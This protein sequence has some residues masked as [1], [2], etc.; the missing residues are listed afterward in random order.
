MRRKTHYSPKRQRHHRLAFEPLESRHLLAVDLLLGE[1]LADGESTAGG[2]EISD[3]ALAAVVATVANLPASRI[4]SF[5]AQVGVEVLDIGDDAPELF[6]HWGTSDGITTIGDWDNEIPLGIS[7]IGTL[8]ADLIELTQNTQYH[9]R[10]RA[11]NLAGASWA[12]S[13]ESFTTI[14]LA[15]ATL[16]TDPAESVDVSTAVIFGDVTDTG[17]DTPEVTIYYGPTDGETDTG[18]W[19]SSVVIG[20]R[21]DSFAT[22]LSGLDAETTYFFRAQASNAFGESWSPL[23]RSFTT[24]AAPELHISEFMAI[25]N[26]TLTTRTRDSTGDAFGGDLKT[27]DWIEVHNLTDQPIDLGGMHLTDRDDELQRWAFPAG[28]SI[29]ASGYLVVFA[30]GDSITDPALD[31]SGRLHTD[32]SLSGGGEFLAL[33]DATG[34]ILDQYDF[35]EQVADISYGDFAGERRYF[36]EPTPGAVN[37]G[38]FTGFVADTK[39]DVDR[40]FYDEPFD[41][42]IT[43]QTIGAEIRYTLNGSEPTETTG[44]VYDGPITIEGTTVLRAAAYKP[45]YQPT[46]VDTHTYIFLD[47][48]LQQPTNPV[49]FPSTWNGT[50]ANYQVDPEI[51]NHPDYSDEIKADL[52]AIPTVSIVTTVEDMFGSSGI[53]SNPGGRGDAWERPASVEW[54]ETDG[55]TLFQVNAG[56][57]VVG[58]ASRGAG[59]KKH[60]F[61]VSFKT[62]YGPG[63][64][65]API[66]GEDA[67][68][69][70]NTFTLRAGFNDVWPNAHNATYLQDRWAAEAQMAMG[71]LAGHGNFV[72]LYVDGLYWGL[73]NPVE[74]PDD[75][76]AASYLGGEKEDYDAYH[77]NAISSGTADAWNKLQNDVNTLPGLANDPAALAVKYAEIEQELDIPAFIDYFI[78]NHYANNGDWPHNNW[79]ATYDRAGNGKWLFHSWDAEFGLRSV[80]GNNV[81]GSTGGQVGNL[82]AKLR[83]VP[84]FKSAYADQI[85]K[86]FFNDGALTLQRNLDWLDEAE[87]RLYEGIVGESA[88]WGDGYNDSGAPRTRDGNWTPQINWLRDTYFPA[89]SSVT[90][91][92]GSS[93]LQQYKNAGLYPNIDAPSLSINGSS[94]HGGF[95]TVGDT[96]TITGSNGTIYYTLDGTDPRL[97]GGDIDPGANSYGSPITV[98]VTTD[99]NARVWTGSEWSALLTA[100]YYVDAPRP[101]DLSITEIN[102]NPYD[103]PLGSPY[104]SGQFEFIELRNT[105]TET[106][107][108]DRVT[109]SGAVTY[110]FSGAAVTQLAPDEYVLVVSDETAFLSRYINTPNS[111][112]AGVFMDDTQLSNSGETIRLANPGDEILQL[113]T[114]ND[115]GPWPGKADGKG[116]ALEVLDVEGDY[117]DPDNWRSSGEVGGTPG[118]AGQG[119]EER[120]VITEVLTHTDLP[121]TDSI[122]LFNTTSEP[123]D[124]GGWFLS[125]DNDEYRK[126]RIPDGTIIAADGYLVF[127]EY[128]FNSSFGIDPLDFALNG[129]H[130]DDVHL[131]K[132]DPTGTWLTFADDVEVDSALNGVSYG[133]W[134]DVTSKLWPMQWTSL[135]RENGY[136][137]VP[138]LMISEINYNPPPGEPKTWTKQAGSWKINNGELESVGNPSGSVNYLATVDAELTDVTVD[139]TVN[140]AED[141]DT[142]P[143][144]GLF[145]MD[146]SGIIGRYRDSFEFLVV[147]IRQFS[148]EVGVW[149]YAGIWTEVVAPVAIPGGVDAGDDYQLSATFDGTMVT[150][151]VDGLELISEDTSLITTGTQFGA[152]AFSEGDEFDD[153]TVTRISGGILAIDGFGRPDST[154]LGVTE[155]LGDDLEFVEILNATDESI[156]LTGWRLR[157]GVDYDFVAPGASAVS[158]GGGETIV[159]VSFDPANPLNDGLTNK[160]RSVHGLGNDVVLVGPFSGKLNNGGEAIELQR[161]DTPPL[162][163]PEFT[164]HIVV[165]RVVYEP[166]APWPDV[167]ISFG[168]LN[169][170]SIDTFGH[171][172]TSW[173]AAVPTPGSATLTVSA[174]R[175]VGVGAGGPVYGSSQVIDASAAGIT[176]LDIYFNAPEFLLGPTLILDGAIQ[177]NDN[178]QSGSG[179]LRQFQLDAAVMHRWLEVTTGGALPAE[180]LFVGQLMGD[181]DG[182]QSVGAGDLSKLF[183]SATPIDIT[184]DG[185]TNAADLARILAMWGDALPEI[186]IGDPATGDAAMSDTAT[187]DTSPKVID[188]ALVELSTD[189]SVMGPSPTFIAEPI[190]P[191]ESSPLRIRR[192]IRPDSPDE[193]ANRLARRRRLSRSAVDVVVEGDVFRRWR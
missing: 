147:G 45:G 131:V 192:T 39:F 166:T 187:G 191:Q 70:F 54:I 108:L 22:S 152:R 72:H 193:P 112:I 105:G 44:N 68:Q 69:E 157:K 146:A 149:K 16:T 32:F 144:Y 40:G 124:L 161:P 135:G 164:P 177:L 171:E 43:S 57:Q 159:V 30:S 139:M 29:V 174:P 153:F 127:D 6:L 150:V 116:S 189:P 158:L 173:Q 84:E 103:A 19:A 89:R 8:S 96:L 122:E 100:T 46:T 134:P 28:T 190:G 167:S 94:Q 114:Y 61:R 79:W 106:F 126:F 136:P 74:R 88:R 47:D 145:D 102:Y 140:F 117:N 154:L 95:I 109:L 13:T 23:S 170:T 175:V 141:L 80:G 115:S 104:T 24:D 143:D 11:E 83:N 55:D 59:N 162:L 85:Q 37:S 156:N 138:D 176:T 185:I 15:A 169:R 52:R 49:G 128:D 12:P 113:F 5:T 99:V 119:K 82:Y 78:V 160:F 182:N 35:P 181:L 77:T 3:S 186:P 73:Y 130:G 41:L 163:E 60:S 42:V 90:S 168:S 172:A 121:Q 91:G 133:R 123:I 20:Q 125:D 34:E 51:V 38:Q 71:G 107:N 21:V 86:H 62:Q 129:A 118:A 188:A 7:G 183:G 93:V 111:I 155:E 92:A 64:L 179:S 63:T 53:Y 132:S 36:S 151:A 58:G 76:F 9:F 48:V 142:A 87:A 98:N 148:G 81:N 25:N 120:I 65:K 4:T 184:G 50:G 75:A 31:E 14:L 178:G 2:V 137:V 10:V 180:S 18:A 27:P 67:A 17:G 56:V 33:T 26:N 110:D 101:G 97:T 66:F 1:D 165:D